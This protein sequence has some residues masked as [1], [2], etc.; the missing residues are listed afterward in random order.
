MRNLIAAV[1]AC[2]LVACG[3][4]LT[5]QASTNPASSKAPASD[6]IKPLGRTVQTFGDWIVTCD[7]ALQCAAIGPNADQSAPGIYIY[8]DAGPDGQLGAMLN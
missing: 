4:S 1:T 7:R 8:R 5:A 6:A 2:L 3:A